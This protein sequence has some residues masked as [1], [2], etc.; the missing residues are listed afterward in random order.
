MAALTG[1][2]KE[3]N[4]YLFDLQNFAREHGCK[5]NDNW[6]IEQV[7]LE[8][9]AQLEKKYEL[10]LVN[11]VLPE[12][13]R[14]LLRLIRSKLNLR[15]TDSDTGGNTPAQGNGQYLVAFH[16]DRTKS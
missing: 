5:T 10:T 9:K 3:A 2:E 6:Q 15:S 14:E 1:I 4:L 13:F 12:N 11:K 7:T 16:T 8:E